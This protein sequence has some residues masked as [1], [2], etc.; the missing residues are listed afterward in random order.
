MIAVL[1]SEDLQSD[2]FLVSQ[3]GI[4]P[5][6]YKTVT[7]QDLHFASEAVDS[8]MDRDV[9]FAKVLGIR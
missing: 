7:A 4:L 2:I 9:A 5:K 6:V 1:W 8:G 3:A